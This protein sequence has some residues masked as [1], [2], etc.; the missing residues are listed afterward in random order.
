[1]ELWITPRGR[2]T[3]NST[4]AWTTLRVAHIPT[5]STAAKDLYIFKDLKINIWKPDPFLS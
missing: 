1:V 5:A 4:P 3:H 2:V